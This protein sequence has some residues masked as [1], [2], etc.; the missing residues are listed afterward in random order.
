MPSEDSFIVG[1]CGA[2]AE[3]RRDEL[4]EFTRGVG[5]VALIG[6]LIAPFVLSFAPF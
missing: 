4:G 6:M 5:I 3:V 1:T 2:W